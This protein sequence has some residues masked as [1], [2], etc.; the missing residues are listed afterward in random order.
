MKSMMLKSLVMTL[1]VV[2]FSTGEVFSQ[3]TFD[4]KVISDPH[5]AGIHMGHYG[6]NAIFG[7]Y[8]VAGAHF[9]DHTDGVTTTTRSGAA[10]LFHWNDATCVWDQIDEIYA[11]SAVGV[12]DIQE[13]A[14]FGFSV[15]IE[16]DL[17]AIGS[18]KYTKDGIFQSG[19]V[20]IYQI[21]ADEAIFV[22][23]LNPL[24][25][26]LSDDTELAAKFGWAV[27]MHGHQLIAS[28]PEE[29]EDDA[30]ISIPN[31]GA[32]YIYRW[33]E[34]TEEFDF[35]NK[36]TATVRNSSDKF[37]NEVSIFGNHAA[38]A[39]QL[40][41][42]D[43]SEGAFMVS[44]GSVFVFGKNVITGVWEQ[45]QKLVAFDRSALDFFGTS[46]DMSQEHIVVGADHEDPLVD[47]IELDNSGSA[48][49]YKWDALADEFVFE[50]KIFP[51]DNNAY[52]EFGTMVAIDNHNILIGSPGH[53]FDELG[54]D[55]MADAGAAYLF[56]YSAGTWVEA[57][58]L[59]AFDRQISDHFGEA[60]SIHSNRLMIGAYGQDYDELGGGPIMSAAGAIYMF[61]AESKPIINDIA[62]IQEGVCTGVADLQ[63]SGVLYDALDWEWHEESCDGPIVG[64]GETITVY[65]DATTTYC[66][67]AIGCFNYV[68][69]EDCECV[70]VETKE[71]NWHQKTLDGLYENGNAIAS[72]SE[73]NVYVAGAY[74]GHSLFDGADN[75]NVLV[76]ADP[77]LTSD[78]KSYV[79]K[80][81]N[82][83]NLLW[84]AYASGS[85]TNDYANDLVL[86][87]PGDYLFIVGEFENQINFNHG[88]GDFGFGPGVI[89]ETRAGKNGYI[90]RL[91][92][93]TGEVDYIDAVWSTG[94]SSN[95]TAIG[96]NE[97]NG[98]IIV[99]GQTYNS[100]GD[101]RVYVRK[102]APSYTTIGPDRASFHSAGYNGAIVNAI[103]YDEDSEFGSG[104]YGSFWLFGDYRHSFDM[105]SLGGPS[106]PTLYSS[107]TD[108]DAFVVKYYDHVAPPPSPIDNIT[109]VFIRGGNVAN[110]S[111][112]RM[113]GVDIAL[114]KITGNAYL[115]GTKRGSVTSAFGLFGHDL[116]ISFNLHN[117]YL[118]SINYDGTIAPAP[119]AE[120]CFTSIPANS[121]ATGVIVVENKVFFMGYRGTSPVYFDPDSPPTSTLLYFGEPGDELLYNC[122]VRF[123]SRHLYLVKWHCKSFR[124]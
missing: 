112:N 26:D 24:R 68:E 61:V 120:M 123:S 27:K 59:D 66:V 67:R 31:A 58:K 50:Q 84:V 78:M 17:I 44:S 81:D 11:E 30:L 35:E 77:T 2:L 8:M 92:M 49:I 51:S 87:E 1:T 75:T 121:Y 53:A 4:T 70:E 111:G 16:D 64:T 119:L 82:C 15:A 56:S 45:T 94:A 3:Y 107:A 103:E 34:V 65:P 47:G 36:I 91:R 105:P 124:Y 85:G 32:A 109:G 97:D 23:R 62:V 117:G 60:L 7:D 115:T 19:A 63:V 40:E 98:K 114:D 6:G 93:S 76:D 38:I 116:P 71:G 55:L 37:G 69:V 113:T 96:I 9:K 48:Y 118:V 33:D 106:F 83:A 39:C 100:I 80:Y 43:P 102:Y 25:N 41:D 5:E 22:E 46:V 110:V 108:R 74:Q 99:A 90:A 13:E 86:Y 29:D 72:D 122:R 101:E 28:A 42:H 54:A 18:P 104:T 14:E 95:L 88:A 73:G 79:A 57:Q 10:F 20:Y 12:L 21:V 52:D 89:S